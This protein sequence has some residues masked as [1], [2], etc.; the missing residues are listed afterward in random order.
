MFPK[1]YCV[2]CSRC[3]LY[4]DRLALDNEDIEP[5]T[6][7]LM[8]HPIDQHR[9][10]EEERPA[11]PQSFA[12]AWRACGSLA[13]RCFTCAGGCRVGPSLVS[14]IRRQCRKWCQRAGRCV[15]ANMRGLRRR[16]GY[17]MW[18]GV[19][20]TVGIGM[21]FMVLVGALHVHQQP[22]PPPA[23]A[24]YLQRPLASHT[25]SPP[26]LS[27]L[28]DTRLRFVLLSR[29]V[30][31]TFVLSPTFADLDCLPPPPSLCP[32]P[33]HSTAAVTQAP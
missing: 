20:A 19:G 1:R 8:A 15:R 27:S 22:P 30:S 17:A 24:L 12:A 28:P 13:R 16:I 26:H 2:S 31:L 14:C 11:V 7:N 10:D 33:Q 9:E 23:P 25:H 32:T 4:Q 3:S 6:G 18:G 21:G 5:P 29:A